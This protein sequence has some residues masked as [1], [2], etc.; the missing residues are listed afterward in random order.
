MLYLT[1]GHEKFTTDPQEFAGSDSKWFLSQIQSGREGINLSTADALIMLN[2]DFSAV[3]YWQAR[4]R[5]Q[6]KDRED[7]SKVCWLFADGGIEE[8]IYKA[9]NVNPYQSP[10]PLK[11]HLFY[12]SD[13]HLFLHN[14]DSNH[15]MC[16]PPMLLPQI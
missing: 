2:I 11:H 14:A 7:A 5:M 4:A 1:F 13:I 8:K 15:P 16:L 9:V 12:V 3:S 6:N 10:L